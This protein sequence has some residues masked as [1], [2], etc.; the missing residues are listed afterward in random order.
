MNDLSP[1]EKLSNLI[2]ILEVKQ[3]MEYEELKNQFDVTV[4][5]II[6]PQNILSNAIAS[7]TS[8]TENNPG[9]VNSL[10]GLVSGFVSGK[11]IGN[12]SNNLFKKLA[13]FGIQY[14]T[15][16]FLSKK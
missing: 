8:D 16:R 4:D 6:K 5:S 1:T 14:I 2:A 3:R 10:L 13:G 11:L 7:F 12:K 15:N 9:I